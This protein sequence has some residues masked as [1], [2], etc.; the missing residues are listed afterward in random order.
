MDEKRKKNKIGM[1][2]KKTTKHT[3]QNS[4]RINKY[5]KN[6]LKTKER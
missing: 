5:E 1:N 3:I 6:I 4:Q 2:S